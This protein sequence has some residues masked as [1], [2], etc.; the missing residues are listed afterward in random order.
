MQYEEANSVVSGIV[1]R[2]ETEEDSNEN[3]E[4]I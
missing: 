4:E 1:I 2:K 3:E